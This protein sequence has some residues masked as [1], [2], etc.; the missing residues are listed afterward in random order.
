ML[1]E[2]SAASRL[3][4]DTEP[5]SETTPNL[6]VPEATPQINDGTPRTDEQ[7]QEKLFSSEEDDEPLIEVPPEVQ[8]IRNRQ[9][10]KMFSAQQTLREAISESDFTIP[11]GTDPKQVTRAVRELRE[12]AADM[13][14]GPREITFIRDRA[15][16]IKAS[17]QDPASQQAAA[18]EALER[19]FGSDAAQALNDARALLLRDPRAANLIGSMNLGNDPE[20]VVLIAKTARSQ[21]AAGKFGKK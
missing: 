13:D 7:I 19:E 5:A 8:A 11:D 9:D 16:A 4:G 20:M 12:L 21:R 18:I 6:V 17:P 15:A 2:A 1:D 10:R 3:F 14:F